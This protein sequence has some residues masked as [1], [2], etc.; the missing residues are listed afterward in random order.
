MM[1]DSDN[2]EWTAE[3]F[4]KARPASE[5]LT[6]IF[7]KEA[8]A[9]LLAKKPVGRPK[10]KDPKIYTGLRLDPEVR[11][12]FEATGKGWQTRINE[13]LKDWLKTHSP[14]VIK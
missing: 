6:E 3:D 13:V 11:R 10:A 7:G 12:A 1:I 14:S 2:P 8:A 9:E 4:E 5:V